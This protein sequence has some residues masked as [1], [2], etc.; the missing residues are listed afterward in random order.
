VES[1]D[2]IGSAMSHK[3]EVVWVEETGHSSEKEEGEVFRK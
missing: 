2:V 1:F 3:K